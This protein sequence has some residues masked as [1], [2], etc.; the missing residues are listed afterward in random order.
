MDRLQQ[1][2]FFL[3]IAN[4]KMFGLKVFLPSFCWCFQDWELYGIL[5]WDSRIP[6]KSE[7]NGVMLRKCC[8]SRDAEKHLFLVK[9]MHSFEQ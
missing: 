7:N 9:L 6:L 2:L 4:M 1:S 8:G 5:S 3:R